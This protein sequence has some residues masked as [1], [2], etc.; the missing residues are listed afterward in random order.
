MNKFGGCYELE[1]NRLFLKQAEK[2]H[3][4]YHHSKQN[5]W[6]LWQQDA[7]LILGFIIRKGMVIP[8]L[9]GIKRESLEKFYCKNKDS[10]EKKTK[11][12]IKYYFEVLKEL[13]EEQKLQPLEEYQ[14]KRKKCKNTQ[15]EGQMSLK[16]F[17][18]L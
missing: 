15:I 11:K 13:L 16:D 3:L 2:N 7:G 14:P 8:Y 10:V 6:N 12:Y 4:I 18:I 1:L 5:Q 9:T 17:G